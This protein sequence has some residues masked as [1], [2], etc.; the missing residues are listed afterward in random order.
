MGGFGLG[1]ARGHDWRR[2][3]G[4]DWQDKGQRGDQALEGGNHERL[5]R[6]GVRVRAVDS[7]GE[8]HA[9]ID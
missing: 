7:R 5:L 6:V 4:G 3:Q 8:E 2:N 1:L 9:L